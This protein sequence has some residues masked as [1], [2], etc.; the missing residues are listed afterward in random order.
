MIKSRTYECEY[1]H[2]VYNEK[3]PCE[4]C[5]DR[6]IKPKQINESVWLSGRGGRSKYPIRLYVAMENGS[7]ITYKIKE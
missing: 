2:M 4:E 1:C 3:Q 6:H 7:A 5:E